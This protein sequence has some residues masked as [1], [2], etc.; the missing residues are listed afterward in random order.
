MSRGAKKEG[1]DFTFAFYP[2]AF[3]DGQKAMQRTL[4]EV[5]DCHPDCSMSAVLSWFMDELLTMALCGCSEPGC[6]TGNP[7]KLCRACE[8]RLLIH[9]AQSL[10]L[11]GNGGMRHGRT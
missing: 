6:L 2:G 8:R 9:A 11:I 5:P 4:E 3:A 1:V 7:P 10:G